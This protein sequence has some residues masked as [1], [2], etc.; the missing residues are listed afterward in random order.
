MKSTSSGP[1]TIFKELIIVFLCTS[2]TERISLSKRN[3]TNPNTIAYSNTGIPAVF[4]IETA[5]DIT[6]TSI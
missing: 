2:D 1:I 4:T 6:L 5:L 3:K